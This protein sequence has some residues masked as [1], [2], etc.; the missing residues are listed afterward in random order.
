MLAPFNYNEWSVTQN[1][2]NLTTSPNPI[3]TTVP[4]Q[5]TPI[6]TITQT[7]APIIQNSIT[8]PIATNTNS[9]N[10]SPNITVS[11]TL[12]NT[13]PTQSVTPSLTP[14]TGNTA[15]VSYPSP[16]SESTSMTSPPN[17]SWWSTI[18]TYL[19]PSYY[20]NTTITTQPISTPFVSN[21]TP[22][23]LPTTTSPPQ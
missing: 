15:T 16:S 7:T 6:P 1:I 4:I 3:Q 9:T 2:T 23:F 10:P 5:D 14:P 13:Q 17:S 21:N 19:I 22:A 11:K 8:Y 20:T 12:S 18:L